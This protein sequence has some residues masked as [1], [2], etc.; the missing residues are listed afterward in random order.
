V[1]LTYFTPSKHR[2]Q[3]VVASIPLDES[4]CCSIPDMSCCRLVV[5]V[6]RSPEERPHPTWARS[7]KLGTGLL[8]EFFSG[9]ALV[10]G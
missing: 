1:S 5:P 8:P 7:P 6:R 9:P 3:G 10:A 2:Y 4:S